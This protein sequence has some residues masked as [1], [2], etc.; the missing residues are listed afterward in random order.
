MKGKLTRLKS[1]DK[2]KHATPLSFRLESS[3]T[4][5]ENLLDTVRKIVLSLLVGYPK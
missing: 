3:G 2:R 1:K 4:A 5:P